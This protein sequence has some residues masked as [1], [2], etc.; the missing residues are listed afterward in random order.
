MKKILASL[1]MLLVLTLVSI[2]ETTNVERA[3]ASELTTL[4]EGTVVSV[5]DG[6]DSD[7]VWTAYCTGGDDAN[8][9]N[10]QWWAREVG[11]PE[12][13]QFIRN[14]DG[15]CVPPQAPTDVCPN[16]EGNQATIPE[17]MIKN[18]GGSCIPSGEVP[19]DVCPNIEGN[20][21]TIPEGMVKNDAGSCVSPETS[22]TTSGGNG[23][24]GR[25]GHSG[26]GIIR[27]HAT[28]TKGRVLGASTDIPNSCGIY[29]SSFM[30]E[31]HAGDAEEVKKLQQFLNEELGKHI[32]VSGIFGP[33]TD[34]AVR[35]FQ[36]KYKGDVLAPWGIDGPSGYVYKTTQRKINLI[37]CAALD[38]P[39]PDLSY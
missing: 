39:M 22:I 12:E 1:I 10:W 36:V 30:R 5:D 11:D 14:G 6:D 4:T 18:E 13:T 8:G 32:P 37:K 26:S 2:P 28:T 7:D 15:D 3:H 9:N 24:S 34:A 17:G 27:R 19:I 33:L 25:S 35:E 31:G 21:A 29:L 20:Q 16:I 38:L 23:H